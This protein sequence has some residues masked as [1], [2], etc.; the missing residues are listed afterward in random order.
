MKKSN[1]PGYCADLASTPSGIK[2]DEPT[3]SKLDRVKWLIR[4]PLPLHG[5]QKAEP[6]GICLNKGFTA[7]TDLTGSN[8]CDLAACHF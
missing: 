2:S 1:A 7:F 6:I 8:Q 5:S 4:S 3:Q